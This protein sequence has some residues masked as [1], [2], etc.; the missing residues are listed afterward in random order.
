MTWTSRVRLL[1]EARHFLLSKASTPALGPPSLPFNGY[2]WHP[3]RAYSSPGVKPSTADSRTACNCTRTSTNAFVMHR[4]K[5]TLT[6]ALKAMLICGQ[7]TIMGNKNVTCMRH[8]STVN[9]N[10]DHLPEIPS[11]YLYFIILISLDN[12]RLSPPVVSPPRV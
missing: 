10:S 12:Y 11:L 8:V 3:T 5:H 7:S 4:D 6:F 1:A 9:Y 2:R